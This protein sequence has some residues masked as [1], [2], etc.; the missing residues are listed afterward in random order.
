MCTRPLDMPC[1]G[2]GLGGLLRIPYDTLRYSPSRPDSANHLL[3][4]SRVIKYGL[5]FGAE[6]RILLYVLKTLSHG[7]E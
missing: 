3:S 1:T 5:P 4:D 7:R 2:G 6:V